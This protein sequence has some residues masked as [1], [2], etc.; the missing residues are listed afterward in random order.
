[1]WKCENSNSEKG[2]TVF[3]F[4]TSVQ[5]C[6]DFPWL[7]IQNKSPIESGP[8]PLWYSNTK[9]PY[10]SRRVF[11]YVRCISIHHIDTDT[12]KSRF[13]HLIPTGSLHLPNEGSFFQQSNG[14][15]S[16][17]FQVRRIILLS[18]RKL[19]H[20]DQNLESAHFQRALTANTWPSIPKRIHSIRSCQKTYL[21]NDTCEPSSSIERLW[22]LFNSN[23][24]NWKAI[25]RNILL[26][27][28]CYL[29]GQAKSCW[30]PC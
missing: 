2:V 9:T 4:Q 18:V 17:H 11:D 6:A 13:I 10:K 19:H 21:P 30:L 8:R 3:R 15:L 29:Q 28:L 25:W 1:M 22:W 26:S 5:G 14:S 7:G 16:S 12:I 23:L 27:L 20:K 24:D